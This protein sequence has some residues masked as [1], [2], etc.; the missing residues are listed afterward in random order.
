MP[1]TQGSTILERLLELKLALDLV[2]LVYAHDAGKMVGFLV[3]LQQVPESSCYALPLQE[4]DQ[5]ENRVLLPGLE[6]PSIP[7]PKAFTRPYG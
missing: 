7:S 5:V 6:L 1:Y 3:A 4:A 2:K